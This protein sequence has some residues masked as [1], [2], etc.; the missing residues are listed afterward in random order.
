VRHEPSQTR[1]NR[2]EKPQITATQFDSE[3]VH[4]SIWVWVA[5]IW[6][7]E[8]SVFQ[9]TVYF[10]YFHSTEATD[11]FYAVHRG[12]H[13]ACHT[14]VALG[15]ADPSLYATPVI[16]PLFDTTSGFDK[17]YL[18]LLVNEIRLD[19][20]KPHEAVGVGVQHLCP[21]PSS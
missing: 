18:N 21:T 16:R 13:Y 14:V 10:G 3:K 6:G 9:L 8:K 7:L 20:N 12:V 2:S 17:A 19:G 15:S 1:A 5:I 4:P 11:T